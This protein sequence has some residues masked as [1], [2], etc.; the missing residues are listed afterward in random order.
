MY[1]WDI[2]LSHTLFSLACYHTEL[3]QSSL[4]FPSAPPPS[5]LHPHSVAQAS[6][7]QVTSSSREFPGR[8]DKDEDDSTM[9]FIASALP[10]IAATAVTP[11]SSGRDV[12][13]DHSGG[14]PQKGKER[15][16][17]G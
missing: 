5:H 16:G 7:A 13:S 12:T 4:H 2:I 6:N 9:G 8:G 17:R 11:P 3:S 1:C 14:K 10:T 15:S